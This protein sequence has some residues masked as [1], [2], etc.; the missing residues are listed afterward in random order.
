MD[1]STDTLLWNQDPVTDDAL[2]LDFGPPTNGSAAEVEPEAAAPEADGP[3]APPPPPLPPRVALA[4]MFSPDPG[5]PPVVFTVEEEHR[6]PAPP[7]PVPRR[8]SPWIVV[9]CTAVTLVLVAILFTNGREIFTSGGRTARIIA[10]VDWREYV[11]PATG[12]R[13]DYP[14]D[15]RVSRDGQYTDFRHPDSAAALRVVVQDS[16]SRSP[17]AAWLELERRFRDEQKSY[18]RIRL[19]PKEFHDYS[20]AE[21][22]FTYSKADGRGGAVQLHNLDLGV[23]TGTK[24]FTLNFE[25]RASNWSVVQAFMER[26]E[27]SFQPPET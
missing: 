17:E 15:W 6:E 14:S 18:S 7:W 22:E 4:R 23:V 27:S 5:S 20:A 2:D 3:P 11:D 19:E 1:L 9:I 12:F 24:A 26:F 25:S 8:P 10:S 16:N 21:W 13:I